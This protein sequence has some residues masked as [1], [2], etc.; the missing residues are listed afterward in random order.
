MKT[1]SNND[2]IVSIIV[3][4]YNTEQYLSACVNSILCQT[5]SSYEIILVDDG[6]SDNSGVLCD[7][8]A[9]EHAEVVAVHQKN[10]GAS[11]ARNVGLKI[12]KGAWVMFVDSDDELYDEYS[13]KKMMDSTA[14]VDLVVGGLSKIDATGADITSYPKPVKRIFSS[15]DFAVSLLN[16]TYGYL[17]FV[18][19][20]IYKTKFL[21]NIL[22]DEE[23]YYCEDQHFLVQF[24]CAS[25]DIKIL[26]DNTIF[27]YKYFVRESSLMESAQKVYNYKFFSD[28]LAYEKIENLLHNIFMDPIIDKIATQNLIGSGSRILSMMANISG[29]LYENQR[30]YILAKF[31]V[32]DTNKQ[33]HEFIC[34]SSVNNTLRMVR[35]ELVDA[36]QKEKVEAISKWMVSENCQF[37]YLNSKWKIVYVLYALL[38]KWGLKFVTNKL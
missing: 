30:K 29:T 12:A 17:G 34:R 38:G 27:V 26:L 13:L 32:F 2:P 6:S 33:M 37:R 22:F 5:F 4:V 20:K 16:S 14:D 28:F 3:P 7:R 23:L 21:K 31:K 9:E 24:L 15:H 25:K 18:C 35:E 10:K 36:N 11:A 1:Q 19:S 8:L